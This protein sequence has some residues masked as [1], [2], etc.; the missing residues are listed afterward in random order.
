MAHHASVVGTLGMQIQHRVPKGPVRHRLKRAL[1]GVPSMEKRLQQHV[2]HA[3]LIAGVL[4]GHDVVRVPGDALGVFAGREH[5]SMMRV[6]GEQI[7]HVFIVAALGHEVVQDQD[8]ASGKPVPQRLE[9]G[10]PF[11]KLHTPF[12]QATKSRL[13]RPVTVVQGARGVFEEIQLIREQSRGEHRLPAFRGTHDQH[14]R[15]RVKTK[16]VHGA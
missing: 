9:V 11:L 12:L 2:P 14:A 7:Q 16:R 4:E 5:V 3:Q 1:D 13:P 15:G 6:F 10:H 8:A